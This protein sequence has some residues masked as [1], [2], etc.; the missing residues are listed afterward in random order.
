MGI[1]TRLTRYYPNW[2]KGLAPEEV[3]STMLAWADEIKT[4][5]AADEVWRETLHCLRLKAEPWPPGIFELRAH[6][7][8]RLAHERLCRTSLPG[9]GPTEEQRRINLE[10]VAEIKRLLLEGRK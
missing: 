4:L 9:P 10:K 2:L 3:R 5:G 7:S 6:V 1:V 8:A